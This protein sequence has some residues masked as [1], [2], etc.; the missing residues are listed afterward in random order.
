MT[1]TVFILLP[2]LCSQ[3]MKHVHR[4]CEE[5]DL[6]FRA[7]LHLSRK[8]CSSDRTCFCGGVESPASATWTT[9]GVFRGLPVGLVQNTVTSAL[10]LRPNLTNGWSL[11]SETHGRCYKQYARENYDYFSRLIG[12]NDYL[13]YRR[14]RFLLTMSS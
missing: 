5:F 11:L 1:C 6:V 10:C 8:C 7:V 2:L 4:D 13:S 12:G 3:K 14:Y 9:S